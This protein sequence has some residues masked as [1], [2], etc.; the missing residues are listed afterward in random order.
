[1]EQK[2]PFEEKFSTTVDLS[3]RVVSLLCAQ[4][5]QRHVM[6][7]V[8]KRVLESKILLQSGDRE[9]S[10][11][12]FNAARV[13]IYDSSNATAHEKW[14]A[15][16][17]VCDKFHEFAVSSVEKEDDF[18]FIE[19]ILRSKKGSLAGILAEHVKALFPEPMT[20]AIE[21]RDACKL[22]KSLNIFFVLTTIII[23]FSPSVY[24]EMLLDVWKTSDTF[25]K[26]MSSIPF[27]SFMMLFGVLVDKLP[28]FICLGILGLFMC[29]SV[30]WGYGIDFM[31]KRFNRVLSLNISLILALILFVCVPAVC[32][33]VAI[34]MLH[35]GQALAVG[36]YLE[37]LTIF[38]FTSHIVTI[39]GSFW[40]FGFWLG[41]L[42]LL[43]AFGL[44]GFWGSLADRKN[45]VSI[46]ELQK[47]LND[48]VNAIHGAPTMVESSHKGDEQSHE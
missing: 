26:V 21:L 5:E 36:N 33:L 30:L 14:N 4:P 3:D 24:N 6:L 15:V 44:L 45:K 16:I 41:M 1:M 17:K 34:N 48:A 12:M 9:N 25:W 10:E 28:W 40:Q 19:K 47:K 42:V 38:P 23:V 7:D 18:M 37:F 13:H 11:L 39:V 20:T 35:G 32:N 31:C 8:I 46:S 29:L 43:S 27:M 22:K 2:N